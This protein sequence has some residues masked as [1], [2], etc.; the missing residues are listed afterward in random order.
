MS[1]QVPESLN[2]HPGPVDNSFF[3]QKVTRCPVSQAGMVPGNLFFIPLFHHFIIPGWNMQN[4]W[5]G[6]P[7]YQQFIVPARKSYILGDFDASLK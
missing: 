4:G 5:V 7:Y 6:I 1:R 3:T 2:I